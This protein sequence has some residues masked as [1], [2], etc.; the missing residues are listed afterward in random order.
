MEPI[1]RLRGEHCLNLYISHELKS[2]LN[3]LAKR[4]DRTTSDMVRAILKIGIPMIEGIT[5]A[6]EIMMKEYVE[7]FRRMRQVRKIKE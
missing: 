5:Q 2:R 7:F 3:E 4:Y 6:E 1:H